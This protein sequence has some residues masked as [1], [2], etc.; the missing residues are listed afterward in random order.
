M[1]EKRSFFIK[2]IGSWIQNR[3]AELVYSQI[4]NYIQTTESVLDLGA[5]DGLVAQLM[6]G[7]LKILL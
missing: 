5:G 4:E 2:D 6:I 1:F 7:K 3:R